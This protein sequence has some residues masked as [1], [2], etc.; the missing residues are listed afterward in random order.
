[1]L[2]FVTLDTIKIHNWLVKASVFDDQILI[3]CINFDKIESRVKIFYDEESAY[4]F[5]ENLHRVL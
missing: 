4:N 5:I 3:I 2:Q 1:M